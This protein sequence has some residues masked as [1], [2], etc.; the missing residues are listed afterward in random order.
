MKQVT[1]A[2]RSNAA[3]SEKWLILVI[4]LFGIVGVLLT[5]NS[6]PPEEQLQIESIQLGK[7]T[8][9]ADPA[10]LVRENLDIAY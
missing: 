6:R 2:A 9:S 10:D 3:G 5:F 8:T 1:N 4:L 7:E